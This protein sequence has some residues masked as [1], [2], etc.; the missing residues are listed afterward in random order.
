MK[1]KL[2]IF[3]AI[4]LMTCCSYFAYGSFQS[5]NSLSDLQLAN[6]EALSKGEGGSSDSWGCWSNFGQGG[7]GCWRCGSPCRWYDGV[8]GVGDAGMCWKNN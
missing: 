6:V 8:K 1:K 3:S 5:G 4:A 7:G 2:L